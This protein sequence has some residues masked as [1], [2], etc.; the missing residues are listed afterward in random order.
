M[1][2]EDLFVVTVVG[3]DRVGLVASLTGVLFEAGLNIVDIEQSVIHAQFTMVLLVQPFKPVFDMRQL[4]RDLEGIGRDLDLNI[5]VMPLGEF[6]GLR[7]AEEKTPYVLTILGSDRPG[8][9][10]A[11]SRVLAEGSANIEKIKMIARGEFLAMEMLVD[12][13]GGNFAPLRER[14][15]EVANE[16]GIDI[17]AQPER[18]YKKRKKI[19][20]FDMDSTIVDAE[21][22]DE[23]A[24]FCGMDREVGEI[25]ERGMRGEIDFAQ[26]L[27]ERVRCLRGIEVDDLKSLTG[28][29]RLTEGAGELISGLKEMGF[30]IALISGGFDFFTDVLKE[31]LGF[32]YAFGNQLE[33]EGGRLTG[34]VKGRIID[35][36]RKA[37]I[38]DEMCTREGVTREE[39]VAVGDGANDQIMVANAGLGI[40]F[41]AKGVLKKVADGSLTKDHLK[42]VLY[43][44]GISET[45]LRA[46]Q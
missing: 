21:I 3:E 1:R 30:K 5:A 39:V 16:I 6:K 46:P 10:A 40:A 44:L 19:I 25:T 37:E 20:V 33:T 23:M 36:K 9:V 38:V 43:C 34:R 41:N 7:L 14:L 2:E 15:L 31:R 35:A 27:R 4:R 17:I 8:V 18:M 11:I 12:I 29:M 22:I 26:S 45:D 32:D 28:S 13:Q 42:G 24:R